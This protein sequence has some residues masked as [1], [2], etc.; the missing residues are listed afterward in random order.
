MKNDLNQKRITIVLGF[1]TLIAILLGW[2]LFQKQITEHSIYVAKA[3][4]QYST[5]KVMPA[6]RGKIYSSDNTLL[7]ANSR[8]YDLSVI[9]AYIPASSRQDVALKLSQLLGQNP[10]DIFAL[11][12]NEKYYLPPL[13]KKMTEEEGQKFADL[14]IKG[15]M[16]TTES[17][18]SYP[19][20]QLASQVLGFVD[21]SGEGIYGLE[22]YFNDELK[23]T[24]GEVS[25]SRDTQGRI[26][27]VNSQVGAQ[28]GADLTLTI[29]RN[30][31]YE[32]EQVLADS[33]TKYMADSGSLIVCDPATGKILAMAN[34]PTYDPNNYNKVTD[35][36]VFNNTSIN[37]A[38]EPGS[39]FKPL[40]MAS[41]IDQ[42]KVQPETQNTFGESVKVDRFTIETS[43]RK[44]HGLENMSQVLQT[45]DNVAMVWISSLLGKDTMYQY[46]KNF[47]FG[48]KTGIELA[49]ETAGSVANGKNWSNSQLAT[50]SFGQGISTT[51]L[52]VLMATNAIANHGKLMQP[53]IVDKVTSPD[54]KVAV[55]Q[56]KT[57][58]QVLRDDTASKLTNMLV[59]VVVSGQ[60]KRAGVAGYDVAGKTGTAQVPSPNGGYY[61]DRWIG[62]FAGFAPASN[63]KFSMIVRLNNPRNV[64]WAESSAAPTFGTMA[65]WI[66]N[67]MNIQPTH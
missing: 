58:A 20:G 31:Q 15:V 12:N 56:P 40:I 61:T 4:G 34:F 22:G 21:S 17:V 55:T 39:V 43:T 53:Y 26:F 23:G 66:L 13:K 48:R 51:P 50:I 49:G 10:N 27:S 45:S 54:S 11:I 65:K 44:A 47:G 36:S 14:K 57:V 37:N 52:Q 2:R 6:E 63:P 29:D 46:I 3:D 32:A 30:I 19:Q 64:D 62:S 16:V 35:P 8:L 60:G 28:N 59:S 33:I 67:Y 7:A 1:F 5:T 24:S 41:A 38:Y 18:R 9:P 42:G 25:G